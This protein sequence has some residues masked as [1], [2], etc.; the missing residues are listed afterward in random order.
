MVSILPYMAAAGALAAALIAIAGKPKWD[1]E[2]RGLR[3][4]TM[5]GWIVGTLAIVA[6]LC[7]TALT[8]SAQRSAELQNAQRE[9]IQQLAHT[10]LRLALQKLA[11]PFVGLRLRARHPMRNDPSGP[12]RTSG[13]GFPEFMLDI[14]YYTLIATETDPDAERRCELS[15]L[16]R[17]RDEV[18]RRLGVLERNTSL[19]SPDTD[20]L[21]TEWEQECVGRNR[22]TRS[23][24][25]KKA[26]ETAATLDRILSTYAYYL[27]PEILYS[28]AEL[29][30]SRWLWQLANLGPKMIVV[31]EPLD[32]SFRRDDALGYQRFWTVFAKLWS[33]KDGLFRDDDDEHIWKPDHVVMMRLRESVRPR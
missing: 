33:E 3:K 16:Q 7:T 22:N 1:P 26:V 11:E 9:K 13:K 27:E 21:R 17:Q 2:K 6:F 15:R 4:L 8:W 32:G 23:D 12:I 5:T 31:E 29:R 10:E 30:R 14:H 25:N 18:E 28:V 20:L 24:I 19:L